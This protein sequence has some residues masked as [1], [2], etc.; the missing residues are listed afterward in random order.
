[1]TEDSSQP[2][3]NTA[4]NLRQLLLE[5]YVSSTLWSDRL[6]NGEQERLLDTV[7]AAGEGRPFIP[8]GLPFPKAG[9]D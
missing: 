9:V 7:L 6:P 8:L 4:A 1:M 5:L 3:E 2:V